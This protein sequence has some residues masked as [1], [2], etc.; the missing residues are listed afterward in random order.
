M[1]SLAQTSRKYRG[2]KA[3]TYDEV[4]QKQ[5]RW[6]VENMVVGRWLIGLKPSDVLDCPVGTGRFMLLYADIGAKHV[7]GIDSSAEM[8]ALARKKVPRAMKNYADVELEVGDA[9]SIPSSDEVYDV[10]VCVR[11]LDLI[12][13]EAMQKVVTEL[14]RVTRRVIICTIRF[15]NKYVPKA[16]TAEHD[17]AK[18]FRLIKKLGWKLEES[19]PFRDAGW[20]ILQ[21]RRTKR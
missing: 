13:E 7:H 14:C 20:E 11:F 1:V 18:F 21:L 19:V 10:S 16:N 5:E 17:R 9:T 2:R 8:I 6:K 3:A 12:D 15:G 4:R